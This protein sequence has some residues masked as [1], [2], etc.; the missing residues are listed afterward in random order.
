MQAS[1]NI[2]L[3]LVSYPAR[4]SVSE[5]RGI[6]VLQ[7]SHHTLLC[8]SS[9]KSLEATVPRDNSEVEERSYSKRF[10]WDIVYLFNSVKIKWEQK[11]LRLWW[12]NNKVSASYLSLVFIVKMLSPS[13][14]HASFELKSSM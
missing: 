9:L 7:V 10:F 13:S 1:E 14:F 6:F 2:Q 5:L 8:K 11:S 12:K 4:T 3:V